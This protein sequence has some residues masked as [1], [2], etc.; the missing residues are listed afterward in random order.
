VQ[1][2]M[3]SIPMSVQMIMRYGARHHAPSTIASFDG[4]GYLRAT[5]ADIADR[6]ARLGA[7]L[8]A[9]GVERGDRVATFCWNHQ[10][11][12]EAYLAI[13]SIGAVL[14]TLNTRLFSAQIAYIADHADDRVL[15][16]DA[17]LLP[18]LREVL[19][20]TPSI[21]TLIVV[22]GK[23][24]GINFAGEIIEYETLLT[25]HAPLTDWPELDENMAAAVCYTS[26]TTGN[27][28]G[29]VYSHK[30]IFVHSLASMGVD[31]FAISQSD[32]ILLLP[33]MFHANA[34]G[35][36]YSGWFA[37]SAFVMPGPHLQPDKVRAMISSERPTFTAMVP[38]LLND[39]IRSHQQSPLDMASFRVIVSG[40]SPVSAA[41][42]ERVRDAWSLPVIQ[43]WGMTETSPLCALSA[44]PAGTPA[45]EEARW[46]T[47]SGRP[48]P[49]VEVRI[50]DDNGKRLPHDGKTVGALQL[51]GPWIARG[52]H[53]HQGED[54]LSPDGWLKTGDVGTID[55]RGY[56]QITDRMKDVIK[57]GGEWISSAELEGYIARHPDVGEVAVIAVADPRWEER[58]LAVIVPAHA[59]KDALAP[60]TLRAHLAGMVAK[61]WLPEYWAFVDEIPKTSVGK[62]DK[63]ALRA[64]IVEGKLAYR[65]DETLAAPQT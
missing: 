1:A 14:H 16:A 34:W 64:M 54:V 45:G 21:K 51:R 55:D 23:A 27:P 9:L 15:I 39:L 24:E 4:T 29:V 25:R 38:T 22:G 18:Q 30:T 7:A 26:G 63:R 60:G 61:F 19:P 8:Q 13:P 42:I 10:Q 52:Y 17:A 46:R 20:L 47:K 49:G 50:V 44:P 11:H 6:A 33:P 3:M 57:S 35:L 28:K 12:L 40:G 58:P 56:V 5:Y 32:R 53:L 59:E 36:P 65:R 62:I 48:V 31:T 2:T 43:G 41:L 37:G